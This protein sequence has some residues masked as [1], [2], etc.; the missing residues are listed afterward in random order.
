MCVAVSMLFEE[1]AKRRSWRWKVEMG[2][3]Y[4]VRLGFL[5]HTAA[6]K[7]Q[8]AELTG[9]NLHQRTSIPL[10]ADLLDTLNVFPEAVPALK[11]SI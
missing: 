8:K 4:F 7:G 9:W 2:S 3:I 5:C 1:N 6:R 11:P 10:V